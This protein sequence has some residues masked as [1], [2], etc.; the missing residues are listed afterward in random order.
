MYRCEKCS[1]EFP[2][3]KWRMILSVSNNVVSRGYSI[4]NS[5]LGSACIKPFCQ[6][7][8]H[9]LLVLGKTEWQLY[10]MMGEDSCHFKLASLLNSGLLVKGR[11]CSSE[12]KVLLLR[13][14]PI[15]ER[16]FLSMEANSKS[17]NLEMYLFT[18]I[19]IF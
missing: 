5:Q 8:K 15:F 14:D 16:M 13:V 17:Q 2:N 12:S 7:P 3:Y 11:I 1:K 10:F 6:T 4:L 19:M 9:S 18:F